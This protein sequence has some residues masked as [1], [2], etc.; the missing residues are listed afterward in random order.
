MDRS[1]LNVVNVALGRLRSLVNGGRSRLAD[2]GRI[3]TRHGRQRTPSRFQGRDRRAEGRRQRSRCRRRRRLRARGHISRG[4]QSRRRRVHD[5]PLPR[6]P[7]RLHRLSRDCAGARPP[8]TM[9]Q[10]ANGNPVPERSRRGYL[11][12]GVPGTVAGLEL[13]RT[14]YG[15]RSRAAL[16]ASAIHLAPRRL[17]ARPGR[18][19]HAC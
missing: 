6:R 3:R 4:R 8:R 11:A 10:D 17:R 15:T 19:G 12:V 16:M 7:H 5:R 9:Y 2:A 1:Q 14:R 18:C 13:A